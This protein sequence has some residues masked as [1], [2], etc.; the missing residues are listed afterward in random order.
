M[1]ALQ[2]TRV[3]LG[4]VAQAAATTPRTALF[5]A[6]NASSAKI[7]VATSANTTATE[8]VTIAVSTGDN[9]TSTTG[10]VSAGSIAS[11]PSATTGVVRVV[12]LDM[13]GKGRYVY[14]TATP[15]TNGTT[16]QVAVGS[17]V[18]VFET[19]IRPDNSATQVGNAV[20]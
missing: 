4:S 15:G 13:R 18:G 2:D 16:A 12:D 19:G 10:Y 17:I 5:D 3:I 8:N 11:L 9:A 1:K 14:V 6:L 20:L 7:L